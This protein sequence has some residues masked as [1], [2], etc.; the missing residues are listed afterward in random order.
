MGVMELPAGPGL[1]ADR[2]FTHRLSIPKLGSTRS[3]LDPHVSP[4]ERRG[5]GGHLLREIK[6]GKKAAEVHGNEITH[7]TLWQSRSRA[8]MDNP[9]LE[10]E[11]S[12]RKLLVQ[13]ICIRKDVEVTTTI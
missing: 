9:N 12:Y 2:L 1:S 3:P 8:V 4:S 13:K 6:W 11:L 10:Q 5:G 7:V